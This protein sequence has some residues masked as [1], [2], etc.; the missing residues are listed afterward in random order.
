MKQGQGQ[1]QGERVNT[2][3]QAVSAATT[4]VSASERKESREAGAVGSGSSGI[5][6]GTWTEQFSAKYQ[7]KY[8]FNKSTGKSVWE[9]PNQ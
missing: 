7:R 2:A 6:G 1:G 9:N 3:Q 5:I 8:W 4:S